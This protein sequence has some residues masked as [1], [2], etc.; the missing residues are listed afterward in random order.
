MLG[1]WKFNL[2]CVHTRLLV[3]ILL[4]L[5]PYCRCVDPLYN[6]SDDVISLKDDN[7][8]RIV[9]ATSNA[10]LIEF[11]NSWCGHC[12]RFA[13]V[14]KQLATDIIGSNFDII[15]SNFVNFSVSR[16]CLPA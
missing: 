15:G 12:I 5:A 8:D 1:T 3:S 14:F 10:W 13:P 2:L 7:F 16:H 6:D 9:L 11:Y 4:L